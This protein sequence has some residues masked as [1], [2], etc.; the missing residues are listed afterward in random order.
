MSKGSETPRLDAAITSIWKHLPLT[1]SNTV[2]IISTLPSLHLAQA[3]MEKY[4]QIHL[5]L[6]VQFHLCLVDGREPS[7]HKPAP[8]VYSPVV[9][10]LAKTS[11]LYAAPGEACSWHAHRRRAASKAATESAPT[12]VMHAASCAVRQ[13]RRGFTLAGFWLHCCCRLLL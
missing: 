4:V 11:L 8:S 3:K 7:I 12:C 2:C 6:M 1:Y 9:P 10:A 13:W 5:C